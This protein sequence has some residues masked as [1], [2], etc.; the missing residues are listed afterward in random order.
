MSNSSS[1]TSKSGNRLAL[2]RNVQSTLSS[3]RAQ[4]HRYLG[5][6]TCLIIACILLF[7]YWFGGFIDYLPVTSGA[8]ETPR[9]IRIAILCAMGLGAFWTV[10]VW[11]APRWFARIKNRSL[12]ILIEKHYPDLDNHLVTAV[13]L[14]E[15]TNYS[16]ELGLD[17]SNPA[18]H[19]QMLGRVHGELEQRIRRV[20]AATLFDWRP[21]WSAG[22]T[23]ALSLLI[24]AIAAV[25]MPSWMG[26]W[27]KR[28]FALSDIPWPR[29][30]ELRAD[31]ILV[32]LPAFTG[33][34]AA[35]RQLIEFEDGVARAPLGAAALFQISARAEGKQVP[36]VCTVFYR[37]D[38]GTRGRANMRRIGSPN[39]GWQQFVLDGPPFDGITQG[40]D[41]NIIGLDARLKDLRLEAIEPVVVTDLDLQ[42]QYPEY[43]LSSLT[44]SAREEIP[45]RNGMRIPQGTSVTISG[46]TS[47]EL[48]L[49]NFVVAGRNNSG[50]SDDTEEVESSDDAGFRIESAATDGNKF[51]IDLDTIDANLVV[52]VRVLDEYGLSSDQ[53]PRYILNMQEDTLPEVESVLNGIGSAIT[54]DAILPIQ[55]T[56][57]DDN[58]IARL[59]VELA[60]GESTDIKFDLDVPDDENLSA[61]VD[62]KELAESGTLQLATG[63]TLGVVVTAQDYYDLD[64]TVHS[65]SGQ[66]KQLSVVTED[67]LLVILDRQELELRQR[68]EII[69]DELS[70][71]GEILDVLAAP[72]GAS[73]FRQGVS[74]ETHFVAITQAQDEE[75]KRLRMLA[76]R[77]QQSVLQGDKSDQEL[78]GVAISVENLWLQLQNN[79]IDSY[80]RQQRLREKVHKPLTEMLT[81][82]Y[83]TLSESLVRTQTA[84]S[85]GSCRDQAAESRA[86]LDVVLLRLTS[87]KENM[88]KIESFNEIIDLVRGLLE[89]QEQLLEA[90]EK[91]KQQ[92]L[93]DLLQ[94]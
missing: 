52:E 71:L 57:R 64:G 41:L 30:A 85:S 22:I 62:L 35:E 47:G 17:V 89:D 7:L 83:P 38:D 33:Q 42:V 26:H 44:R 82:E 60:S 50:T 29:K 79:R 12:A 15:P 91:K 54:T 72:N 31:G 74:P 2:G 92:S 94:Q 77:A 84:A 93:F 46:T 86:A 67:E 21:V 19:E 4:L 56:V 6:Q 43:L 68:L 40:L 88:L 24:T 59:Y 28:L 25:A 73:A 66:P 23:V 1:A 61:T 3:V 90:T 32:P 63:E 65:G 10:F 27:N 78:V 81:D 14:S 34:L 36:E 37:M 49:A 39:D 70:Q 16:D 75:A 9:W 13:E 18:A 80:D 5:I 69:I 51:S 8:S 87:I 76:I 58:G 53:L 20:D 45:Y 11:A 55:G 48:T